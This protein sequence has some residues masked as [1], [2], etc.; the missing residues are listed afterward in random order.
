MDRKWQ[1]V[2]EEL[3]KSLHK[4]QYDFWVSTLEYVGFEEGQLTVGCRNR[5]HVDWLRDKLEKVLINIA[6]EHF[7]GIE[8]V[9]YQIIEEDHAN[10]FKVDDE[11][12]EPRQITFQDVIKPPISTFNPRFTFD[13]FVTGQCNQFAYSAAMAMASGQ[14]FCYHS[15]YILSETGLGKSHL[16]QSI[17]NHLRI[18]KPEMLVRYVTAE[19]FA[20][21]M[22]FALKN[23]SIEHFKKKYR[24][25]CD[26]LLLE[27]IEFLSGKEKIQSEL[28]YTLDELLDRGKSI[29][30]TG[31]AFPRDIPKL[32]TELKSRL[33]GVLM[34][35]IE[36]PDFTTRVEI[37]QRKAFNENVHLPIEVAEFLAGRISGDV[38]RLESC[39]VGVIVKSNILKVPITLGLAQDVTQTMLEHLPRLTIEHIQE[40]VCSTFKTSLEDMKSR[41][42]RKE[43][44]LAR[45]VTMY[46]CRHYTSQSLNNI[47]RAFDRSHS[48]VVYAINTLTK[49]M[50]G[51]NNKLRRQLD[52]LSKRLET[53]CL[54]S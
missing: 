12:R 6:S 21:E 54:Y 37:I 16:S 27:R 31:K 49:K 35:P 15:V 39:L 30:C 11:L 34:A 28:V 18:K 1:Q 52:Y 8:A 33:S 4:G 7:P 32:S 20:N 51:K 13:Q 23:D 2:K 14:P 5:L 36:Q 46:L 22:I 24:E 43:I 42:R 19:Q 47:G 26:L 40:I 29:L 53:S 38:R 48:S 25:E 10:L 17:G 9:E 41:T 3:G 45:Q 44:A 50:E